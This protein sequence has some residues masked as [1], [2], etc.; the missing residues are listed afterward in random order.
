MM[1]VL[2]FATRRK[3]IRKCDFTC[4]KLIRTGTV[5][6]ITIFRVKSEILKLVFFISY[7]WEQIR[8][9]RKLKFSWEDLPNLPLWPTIGLAEICTCQ[10]L[11]H[12]LWSC[13]PSNTWRKDVSHCSMKKQDLLFF[14]PLKGKQITNN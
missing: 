2:Y 7:C 14:I 10:T 6:K 3:K 8:I 5:Q 12:L 1:H 4:N 13:V 9:A 11:L